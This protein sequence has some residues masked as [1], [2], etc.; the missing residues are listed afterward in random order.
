MS[1]SHD[2]SAVPSSDSRRQFLRNTSLAAAG[3]AVVAAHTGVEARAA[4]AADNGT[5][6][7]VRRFGAVGDGETDDTAALREAIDHAKSHRIGTVFLPAGVF[8]LTGTLH[9]PSNLTLRGEGPEATVLKA[10]ADTLFDKFKPDPRTVDIRARRTMITTEAV[11]T[12]REQVTR[13]AAVRGMTIDWNDC[14]TEEYGHSVVLADSSDHFVIDDVHF[15]NCLPSDHPRDRADMGGSAF[16]CECIMYCNSRHGLMYRCSLT[17]SGYR[18]L[19]VSYNSKQIYFVNGIITATNPVWRHVFCEN[20]GD[21]MPRDETFERSQVIFLNSTFVLEGGTGGDGICSHTGTTHV[22][23]CDFY[24]NGG[25]SRFGGML[26]PFDGSRDCAYINNRFHCNVPLER[27]FPLLTTSNSGDRGDN[28]NITLAGNIIRLRYAPNSRDAGPDSRYPGRPCIAFLP[29][30]ST[31]RNVNIIGN[32]A[33]LTFERHAPV[34]LFTFTNAT[35]VHMA[36]N[37]V[38]VEVLADEDGETGNFPDGV[39]LN[40]CKAASLHHNVFTGHVRN[41]VTLDDACERVIITGNDVSETTGAALTIDD[42]SQRI[43]ADHNF[44]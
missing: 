30:R 16:R 6:V 7:D 28:E 14:P 21:L 17:D 32:H 24:I 18:P 23:N 26:R 39:A 31:D 20:H 3:A 37:S 5:L 25:L 40:N 29:E 4:E 43:I 27:E 13:H 11:T 19:S 12:V 34:N 33:M 1:N 9:L 8:I 38:H 36:N 42:D 35:G 41:G 10:K 15:I 2:P 22:E 44:T